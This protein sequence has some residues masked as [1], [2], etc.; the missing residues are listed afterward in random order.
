MKEKLKNSPTLQKWFYTQSPLV[1]TRPALRETAACLLFL[2]CGFLLSCGK[3]GGTPA[4]FALALLASVGG[5][6]RGLTCLIGTVA[7]Y[8]TMQPFSQGLQMTSSGILIYVVNYIFGSLWVTKRSWFR[9]TVAGGMT[10]AV[11]LIFLLSQT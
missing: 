9:C 3:L 5:G 10:G 11:G 2:I 4:P 7:G 8:L 1:I 6:L